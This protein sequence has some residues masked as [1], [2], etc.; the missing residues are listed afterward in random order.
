[1][2]QR[3]FAFRDRNA[4]AREVFADGQVIWVL[5]GGN[6]AV[7]AYRLADGALLGEFALL[8]ENANPHGMYSDGVVIWVSDHDDRRLYAYRLPAVATEPAPGDVPALKL[9]RVPAEEFSALE[10]AGNNAPRGIFSDGEIMYAIDQPAN[11][12]YT[13]NMPDA[14]DARLV[15]LSFDGLIIGEFSPDRY[16]YRGLMT[17]DAAFA[18]V[19]ALPAQPDAAVQ[20]T[21]ADADPAAGHQ[22]QLGPSTL[23]EIRVASPDGSRSRTYQVAV[24]GTC[25]APP[26]HCRRSLA[27]RAEISV[28]ENFYHDLAPGNPDLHHNISNLQVIP[29]RGRAERR[30]PYLLQPHWRGRA[31]GLPDF[32][33]C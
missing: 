3:E 24:G 22:L 13:Y 20:I 12:V 6:N 19:H 17:G 8:L 32:R 28:V 9:E 33:G 23:V 18:S 5:D 26:D 4:D 25:R 29:G 30:F 31:L 14:I 10:G 11:R 27:L 7:F 2:R 1:M 16:H 15:E 21:P